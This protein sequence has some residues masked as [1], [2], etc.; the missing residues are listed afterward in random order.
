MQIIYTSKAKEHL[1]FWVKSG[2]KPVLKKIFLLTK[3]IV[4]SP[5]EGLGKPEALKY[6]LI[7]CWSRRITQVHRLVYMVRNDLITILSIKG[8]Y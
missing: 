5:Y 4:E 6:N 7:N 1:D 2:N 8:Q 3:A